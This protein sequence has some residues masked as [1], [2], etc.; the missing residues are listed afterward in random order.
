MDER[1]QKFPSV[2]GPGVTYLE[3]PTWS[4]EVGGILAG[5]PKPKPPITHANQ[6]IKEAIQ[7]FRAI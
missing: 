6:R 4:R 7:P 5:F 3:L 2:G 1:K